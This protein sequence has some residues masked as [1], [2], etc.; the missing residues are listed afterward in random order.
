MKIDDGISLNIYNHLSKVLKLVSKY[1]CETGESTFDAYSSDDGSGVFICI[2]NKG[3]GSSSTKNVKTR[4]DNETTAELI[5]F[6]QR[7]L[8]LSAKAE[9]MRNAAAHA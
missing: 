8:D 2:K 7:H 4:L 5:A 3:F 1:E 6:L 9:A